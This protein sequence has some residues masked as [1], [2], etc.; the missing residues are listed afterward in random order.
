MR[1]ALDRRLGQHSGSNFQTVGDCSYP[2]L[3]TLSTSAASSFEIIWSGSASHRR[4]NVE[5]AAD[6]LADLFS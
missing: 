5:H 4:G 2:N 3:G 6:F 1:E